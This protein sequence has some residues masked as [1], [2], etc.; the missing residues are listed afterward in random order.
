[1]ID[2]ETITPQQLLLMPV[3]EYLRTFGNKKASKRAL[4]ILCTKLLKNADRLRKNLLL[5]NAD[6]LRKN[7]IGGRPLSKDGEPLCVGDLIRVPHP[8]L[9]KARIGQDSLHFICEALERNE[10]RLNMND[11]AIEQ[12]IETFD[13]N[14]TKLRMVL[15]LLCRQCLREKKRDFSR[16]FDRK[17][18]IMPGFDCYVLVTRI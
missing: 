4:A 7:L 18:E 14:I 2:I 16:I 3:D 17:K 5:K 6:R 8:Y 10:L 1:M 15:E 11:K 12:Y 13:I 9:Y